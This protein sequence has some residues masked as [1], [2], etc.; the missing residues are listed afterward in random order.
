MTRSHRAVA[1]A[2]LALVLGATTACSPDGDVD[3]SPEPPASSDTST[4]TSAP[5]ATSTPPSESP[6]ES[7]SDPP[8]EQPTPSPV[9]PETAPPADE[10]EAG[11]DD[12]QGFGPQDRSTD[13]WPDT[14]TGPTFLTEVRA[15]AHDGYDR[16][17]LEFDGA[18]PPS[19]AARYVEE[20]IAEGSGDVLDVDGEVFLRIDTAMVVHPADLEREGT[21]VTGPSDVGDTTV[22][23]L[24]SEGPWEG[25]AATHI[26]LD[27]VRDFRISTLTDPARIVVDIRR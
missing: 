11:S 22:R 6:S 8:A 20:P 9:P 16:V 5:P 17:V 25:Y 21:V 12:L 10:A 14:R 26:G 4:T 1:A 3:G 27:A 19:W 18:E 24:W 13:P 15:A 23:G 7:P 2:A